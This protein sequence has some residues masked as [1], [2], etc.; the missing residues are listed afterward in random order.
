[1]DTSDK[2]TEE[3]VPPGVS[4]AE[5]L[6]QAWPIFRKAI[7][8]GL[9]LRWIPRLFTGPWGWVTSIVVPWFVDY[10]LKPAYDKTARKVIVW[11]RKKKN[12]QAGTKLE[13]SKTEADFNSAS[14]NLP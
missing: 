13:E 1:M 2:K 12:N 10:V 7:I 4:W 3:Q 9:L 5:Y 6:D 8:R 14:D 11:V